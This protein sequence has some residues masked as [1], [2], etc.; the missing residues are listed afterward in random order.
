M[1]R[2]TLKGRSNSSWF[3]RAIHGYVL[4]L[5]N[6]HKHSFKVNNSEA[7][8]G[9]L[10]LIYL[11]ECL[12]FFSFDNQISIW[13]ICIFCLIYFLPEYDNW[14]TTLFFNFV[15]DILFI[16]ISNAIPKVPY[17][18]PPALLPYPPT[19]TSWP[20][21]SPVL[22]HIKFARPRGLSSQW[23]PTRP[24]SAT[25]AARDMSSGGTD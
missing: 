13:M 12:P 7:T 24:F 1:G 6:T 14:E 17:T 19:P 2:S 22:G 8:L 15:L 3:E 16:Y 20:W 5:I 4:Y 10:T 9:Q 11:L 23:W 18:L 21:H 25:Y